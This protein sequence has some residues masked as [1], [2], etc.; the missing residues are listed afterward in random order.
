MLV[1]KVEEG[2]FSLDEDV[3]EEMAQMFDGSPFRW[4]LVVMATD[5]Q[6]GEPYDTDVWFETFNDAYEFKEAVRTSMEPLE[7]NYDDEQRGTL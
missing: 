7:V 3:P 4:W 6:S 5:S 2:P 1:W